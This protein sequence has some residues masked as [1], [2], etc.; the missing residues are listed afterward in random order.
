MCELFR[1]PTSVAPLCT[2]RRPSKCPPIWFRIERQPRG[3]GGLRP[4]GASAPAGLPCGVPG[5]SGDYGLRAGLRVGAGPDSPRR[6]QPA[7]PF[8]GPRGG[9]RRVQ[10]G[11]GDAW[12]ANGVSRERVAPQA[13][14][15]RPRDL[16]WA[17]GATSAS[18]AILTPHAGRGGPPPVDGPLARLGGGSTLRVPPLPTALVDRPAPTRRAGGAYFRHRRPPRGPPPSFRLL[19]PR[20]PRSP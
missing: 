14:R 13:R 16:R 12:P 11:V 7:D 8:A 4:P 18:S 3:L 17:A 5:R 2:R 10:A 9:G 1:V 6:T 20:A 19:L 15:R